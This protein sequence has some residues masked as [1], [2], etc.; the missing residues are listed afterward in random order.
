[1]HSWLSVSDF[2]IKF[3]AQLA[4]VTAFAATFGFH[5]HLLAETTAYSGGAKVESRSTSDSREANLWL[6]CSNK[7]SDSVLKTALICSPLVYTAGQVTMQ[8]MLPAMSARIAASALARHAP[9]VF[10]P[11]S[12]VAIGSTLSALGDFTSKAIRADEECYG[13]NNY[14]KLLMDLTNANADRVQSACD[15]AQGQSRRASE[16]LVC[17]EDKATMRVPPGYL[18]D[19][20]VKSLSCQ[21]MYQMLQIRKREQDARVGRL[22]A[23]QIISEDPRVKLGLI[24]SDRTL[25]KSIAEKMDCFSEQKRAEM[26]CAVGNA[27]L[28]GRQ[29]TALLKDKPSLAPAAAPKT[30]RTATFV[31]RKETD[32]YDSRPK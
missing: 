9:K 27:A 1:M 8:S 18:A 11:L 2:G 4:W 24:E 14:K 6:Q 3:G 21:E 20:F 13:D 15:L 26:L 12:V 25:V 16:S 30:D 32:T 19:G 28:M 7:N 29:M 22:I 23:K 17:S 31:D 5:T 10:I